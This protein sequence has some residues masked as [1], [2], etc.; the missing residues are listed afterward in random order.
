MNETWRAGQRV[1]NEAEPSLGLGVIRRVL[2]HR[3]LEIHFRA[4][5]L[6]HIYNARTAPLRRVVLKSGQQAGTRDGHRFRVTR[7]LRRGGLLV[8]IDES[9]SEVRE[10]ELADELPSTGVVDQL[11]SG[12]LSHSNDYDLRLD[13]W[14]LRQAILAQRTR[15]L[16]SARVRLLGH[17]L[18]V[19]HKISRQEIPRVLLADEVGLG[20][21]IEAG[22]IFCALRSLGR[23]GRVLVLVPESLVHQWLAEMVR[24]FHEMFV[25]LDEDRC[26]D[27]DESVEGGPNPFEA[28]GRAICN[29]AFLASSPRR[30]KQACK[31]RWDLVIVDEAHHL[32]WSESAESSMYRA[33]RVLGERAR[34]LLLLT[35]TPSRRGP[36]SE[37]G[38][39]R[40]VDP[41][42]FG[43]LKS[44]L[45]EQAQMKQVAEVARLL[46][47]ATTAEARADVAHRLQRLFP[48]DQALGQT[49]ER[50]CSLPGERV[51][52][53]VGAHADEV[54]DALLDRHGTG[55]VLVRNRRDRLR[56]FPERRLH[57]VPLSRTGQDDAHDPRLSWLLQFAR[58]RRDEKEKVLLITATPET[59]NALQGFIRDQSRVKA[60]VFHERMTVVER[61]RQAAWFADDEGATLLLCSEIGGEGRNFQFAHH[62]VLYDLP[63]DPDLLEQRIGRLDRIGQDLPVEIHALYEVDTPSEALFHWHRDGLGA[64]E[65]PVSGAEQVQEALGD[66]LGALL[67]TWSP[68]HPAFPRRHRELDQLLRLTRDTLEEV[69][70]EISRSV[71]ELVDLNSYDPLTGQELAAEIESVD[72][73]DGLEAYM[74]RAFERFGVQEEDMDT[75][76]RKRIRPGDLMFVDTFPGLP[77]GEDGIGVTYRRA[78]ALTREDLEF[79]TREHPLVEGALGLILDQNL[80][81]A[82][83]CSWRGAPER[84]V[85]VL[86]LFLL[87]ARGPLRLELQRYLPITA[88]EVALDHRAAPRPDLRT[89]LNNLDARPRLEKV[90]QEEA[91]SVLAALG[92]RVRDLAERAAKMAEQRCREPRRQA[93]EHAGHS[94]HE[95]QGR[96]AELSRVNRNIPVAELEA[97]ALKVQQTLAALEAAELRLDAV[98][99][100]LMS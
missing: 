47:F 67:E 29:L 61:D 4:S 85:L 92:D 73:D 11:L 22:L 46:P 62:L 33:V 86:F 10:Q 31:V 55:R 19:A 93:L 45:R 74:T 52:P 24:R 72:A 40:L 87:E 96:L 18:Y 80:G 81:R 8:Y 91:R 15:G 75:Q 12:Q 14:R 77:P 17:Q 30:L 35:A 78:L 56:G 38:L 28:A 89:L 34:S 50:F 43:D 32:E 63:L 9:G 5:G 94:L 76:G 39:L 6:T 70:R 57:P 64:F 100:I 26:L 49:L 23:A 84:G 71:D 99:V 44:F 97:H 79:I 66:D 54:L 2:D 36:V 41:R 20:K 68:R 65:Q 7:I 25:L 53:Q 58:K 13:G 1:L 98:R 69:R 48:D 90:A 59:V 95:E 3:N 88:L 16:G 82:T 42:R 60:A 21:T 83:M 27:L 37:F 51:A